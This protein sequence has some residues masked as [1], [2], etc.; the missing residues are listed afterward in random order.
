VIAGFLR[1]GNTGRGD[2]ITVARMETERPYE[3]DYEFDEELSEPEPEELD[4][5]E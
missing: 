5:V 4:E 2:R 1:R 3:D